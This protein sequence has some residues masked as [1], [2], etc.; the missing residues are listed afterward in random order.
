MN[1]SQDDDISFHIVISVSH[2]VPRCSRASWPCRRH[3]R[4]CRRHK[5]ILAISSASPKQRP[6]ARAHHPRRRCYRKEYSQ[7]TCYSPGH[8]QEGRPIPKRMKE[9]YDSLPVTFNGTFAASPCVV[10]LNLLPVLV[11]GL[12]LFLLPQPI[13]SF[14]TADSSPEQF[15]PVPRLPSKQQPNPAQQT[16]R[17]KSDKRREHQHACQQGEQSRNGRRN[18]RQHDWMRACVGGSW[19]RENGSTWT[20]TTR[21][22]SSLSPHPRNCPTPGAV[23]ENAVFEETLS[24]IRSRSRQSTVAASTSAKSHSNVPHT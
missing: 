7:P 2:H 24:C 14:F 3:G 23:P 20:V 16:P 19:K 8:S 10:P 5:W 22:C 4:L 6:I 18:E 21:S 9:S 13:R 12:W 11:F 1:A 15:P 17:D